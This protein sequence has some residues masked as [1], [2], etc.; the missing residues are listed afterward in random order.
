MT[1]RGPGTVAE[2]LADVRARVRSA[3]RRA[4]RAEASVRLVA[5]SKGI[6]TGPIVEALDAGV[7][8]LGESRAQEL[9]AKLREPALEGREPVWHFVGRIQRNKVAGLAKVVD[10]W[11]SV[12]RAEVGDAIA[13]RAPGARVLVE[14]NVS[15]DP[16][17]GGCPRSE[18]PRLVESLAG[19]G[20]AVEG[21]MTV[22]ALGPD[23]R[24]SFAALTEM[25]GRLGL[26]EVSMGMSDDFELAVEEGST[27]I[28]VGRAVF[29]PRPG[30]RSLQR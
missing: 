15:K 8:D 18:A 10:L 2:R 25:A 6:A 24:P 20:L 22:P 4:G 11:H 14:V 12:D 3:E 7:C 9:L 29:G 21:L 19:A 5:V 16:A 23:P 30:E 13:R 17:K 1:G 26:A 28:R 27:M